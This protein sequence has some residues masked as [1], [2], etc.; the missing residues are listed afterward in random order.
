MDNKYI[1]N[2]NIKSHFLLKYDITEHINN[3]SVQ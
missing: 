1:G 3:T 2:I